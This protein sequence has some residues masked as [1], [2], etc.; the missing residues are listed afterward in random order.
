MVLACRHGINK[1]IVMSMN[2]YQRTMDIHV[3][4]LCVSCLVTNQCNCSPQL[5]H[6]HHDSTEMIEDAPMS[7]LNEE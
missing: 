5:D 1:K 3:L 2:D 7:M 6:R 4:K